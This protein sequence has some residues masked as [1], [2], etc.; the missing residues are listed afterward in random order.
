MCALD[1]GILEPFVHPVSSYSFHL[2]PFEAIRPGARHLT[3]DESG[4][5]NRE[6]SDNSRSPSRTQRTGVAKR[7]PEAPRDSSGQGPH[8]IVP[9]RGEPIS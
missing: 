9:F 8:G 6:S 4:R 3:D 1:T 2:S 7:V 5:R